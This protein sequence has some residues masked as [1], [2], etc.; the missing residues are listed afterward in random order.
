MDYWRISGKYY[1][2]R[3][4][5]PVNI[6]EPAFGDIAEASLLY[7]LPCESVIYWLAQRSVVS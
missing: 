5:I 4:F 2:G 7:P 3:K 6:Y 1:S